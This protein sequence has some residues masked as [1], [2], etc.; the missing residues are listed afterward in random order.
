MKP[1]SAGRWSLCVVLGVLAGLAPLVGSCPASGSPPSGAGTESAGRAVVSIAAGG[2]SG[3]ALLGDGQVWA[4]GDDLEGQ[5][6]GAGQWFQ[7]TVPVAVRGLRGRSLSLPARTRATPCCRT[8]L[9]GRG[10]TTARMSSA[11][12]GTPSRQVPVQVHP[13]SKIV[14]IAAGAFSVYALRRDDTVWTWGDKGLGQLGSGTHRPSSDTLVRVRGLGHVVA[15]SAGSESRYALD[16]QGNLRAWDTVPTA[17]W[18]PAAPRT[19]TFRFEC[20]S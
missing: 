20:E 17:S 12:R 4:W 14:T 7:T 3:Y 19:V 13:L 16:R 9:C 11:T 10:A 2:Y 15:I 6:G 1:M 5:I 8:A 18:A